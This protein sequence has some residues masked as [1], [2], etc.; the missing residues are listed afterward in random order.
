MTFAF[1]PSRAWPSQNR[2]IIQ[3]NALIAGLLFLVHTV[4]KKH[5]RKVIELVPMLDPLVHAALY[6]GENVKDALAAETEKLFRVC[7]DVG[8]D[9]DMDA[10]LA[11]LL[12]HTRMPKRKYYPGS[13]NQKVQ[14]GRWRGFPRWPWRFAEHMTAVVCPE[15]RDGDLLRYREWRPHGLSGLMGYPAF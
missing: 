10:G 7:F 2:C 12:Q 6:F 5:E 8:D 15:A 9:A 11:Y 1:E 14:R 4:L 3:T 13:A